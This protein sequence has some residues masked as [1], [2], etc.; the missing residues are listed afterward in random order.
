MCTQGRCNWI[1]N[2]TWE[3]YKDYKNI[4]CICWNKTQWSCLEI[5]C[6]ENKCT[7]EN[8]LYAEHTRRI[9]LKYE[10]YAYAW[11]YLYVINCSNE[12]EIKSYLENTQFCLF[13]LTNSKYK[14]GLIEDS[15]LQ[16]NAYRMHR[17]T[18]ISKVQ[19][20]LVNPLNILFFCSQC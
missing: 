7:Y 8:T 15:A 4:T 5:F 12:N 2:C 6:I 19:F 10:L 14:Y 20:F 17:T 3:S 1:S 11:E 9:Y 18:M 16:H 13:I